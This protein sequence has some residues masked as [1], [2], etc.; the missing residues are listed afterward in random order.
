MTE[1]SKAAQVANLANNKLL[2]VTTSG[3][4]EG[5]IIKWEGDEFI[6]TPNVYITN[7]A[8]ADLGT[9]ISGDIWLVYE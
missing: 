5:D 6:T 4:E 9:S 8:P 2:D 3:I 1:I 7:T